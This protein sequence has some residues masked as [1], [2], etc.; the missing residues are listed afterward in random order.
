MPIFQ[1]TQIQLVAIVLGA[2]CSVLILKTYAF[3]QVCI[4]QT[5]GY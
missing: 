2:I 5:K 3:D 1:S 4:T